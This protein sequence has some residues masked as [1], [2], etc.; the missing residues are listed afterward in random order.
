M[1]VHEF[2]FEL[3]DPK[4]W[5]ILNY[6]QH[7]RSRVIVHIFL[8]FLHH[9]VASTLDQSLSQSVSVLCPR[10]NCLFCRQSQRTQHREERRYGQTY[11]VMNQYQISKNR[12]NIR[13][14]VINEI[15]ISIFSKMMFGCCS[16]HKFKV[17]NDSI[18]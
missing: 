10:L 5:G 9:Y 6:F 4:I 13:T 16:L 12:I 18:S 14:G 11:M 8:C 17:N 15:D 7:S 1:P 3:Q 2:V